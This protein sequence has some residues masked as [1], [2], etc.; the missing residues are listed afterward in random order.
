MGVI[1]KSG[2]SLRIRHAHPHEGE[3]LREIAVASKGHWGYESELVQQWAAMGDFSLGGLR[4]KEVYVAEAEG[5][6]VAWAAL[7]PR[8]E[9][10]W[11][12]DLWVEPQWIGKGVGSLLFRHAVHRAAELGGRKMEWAAEPNSVGFYERLGGRYLRD[13]EPTSW[14]RAIPVM[15][16]DLSDSQRRPS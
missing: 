8:G 14:G 3:R 5:R 13:S 16:V 2:P 4:E 6:A 1:D 9:L 11:L 12:D 7:I 15:G 10:V